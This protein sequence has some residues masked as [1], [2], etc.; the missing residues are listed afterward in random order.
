MQNATSLQQI[1]PSYIREIL[2]VASSPGV[3]S[4][5]GGLPDANSFPLPLMQQSLHNMSDK[6]ELFQY[7]STPGYPPL[8]RYCQTQYQLADKHLSLIC[9][10]SQQG[11][12]LIARA[13]INPGDKIVMEAPSYL[14]ALQVFGLAQADIL[15]ISSNQQGPDLNALE[16]SFR[17]NNVKIFYAVP[18]FHNPT[19]VCWSLATRHKVA[20]LCCKYKVT[21]LEDVPYRE[22][23]FSGE[24]LPLVS[25]FCIEHSL[26]LRSFSKFIAPGMRLGVVSGKASWIKA[27]IKVKQAAD[28][29]TNIPMQALLLDILQ[30]PGF[31]NHLENLTANYAQRYSKMATLIDEKLPASCQ[32]EP[33]TGGMFIW[34]KISEC[35]V[36]ELAEKALMLGVA[37]VPSDVFYTDAKRHPCALRLNFSHTPLTQIATG[38]DRLAQ[39]IKDC[40]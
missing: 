10:G 33:V 31:A 4:F 7:A 15:S 14:G 29:H 40:Q 19:G 32:F 25:S 6:P 22:L 39:S 2:T 17:D 27:L 5:A 26:V 28:L 13:F 3:I 37:V 21:L 24:S 23:R 12:D 30:H 1:K 11:L 8:L 35:D 36:F 20:Q 9:N 16:Y 38:L 18:D 34:L